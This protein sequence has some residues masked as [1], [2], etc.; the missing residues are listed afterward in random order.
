MAS[1]MAEE[2]G[3]ALGAPMGE[4][5]EAPIDDLEVAAT[6]LLASIKA[7]DTAGV[8]AALRSAHEICAASP[9]AYDDEMPDEV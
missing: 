6:D 5:E 9:E 4:E 7:G 2:L 3:A 8:A 1:P